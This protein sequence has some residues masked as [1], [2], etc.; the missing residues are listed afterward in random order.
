M[1]MRVYGLMI[2]SKIFR[3]LKVFYAL[4]AARFVVGGAEVLVFYYIDR[5]TFGFFCV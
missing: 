1:G 3:R 2:S 4:C 5:T